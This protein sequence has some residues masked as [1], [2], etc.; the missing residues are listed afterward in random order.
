MTDRPEIR[1]RRVRAFTLLEMMIAIAILSVVVGAI[2]G[3]WHAIMGATRVAR[4]VATQVQQERMAL[5]WIDQSL[6]CAIRHEANL[7]NYFFITPNE[8]RN[9]LSFVSRLPESFPRS[10]R[11]DYA[12]IRR[13][14]FSLQR[15]DEGGNDLVLRQ[16]LLLTDEFDVDEQE[17]PLV[18]MH[19]VREMTMEYW[20][21]QQQEW[22]DEWT[23]SNQIPAKLRVTLSLEN[24][25]NSYEPNRELVQEI[26]PESVG[27][28]AVLQARGGAPGAAPGLPGGPG[29]PGVPGGPGLAPPPRR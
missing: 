16:R 17:H 21:L 6:T 11:F 19:H 27:V 13:V 7:T 2:Y 24:T 12:P 25:R 4:I 15:G 18:L 14:E 3:T 29:A 8:E 5:R 26:V 28:P 10:G 22:T 23:S 1:G 9:T 20:D